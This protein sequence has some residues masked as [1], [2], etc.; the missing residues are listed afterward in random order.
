MTMRVVQTLYT[1]KGGFLSSFFF[2]FLSLILNAAFLAV[3]RAAVRE[4]AKKK[5][6]NQSIFGNVL[7][8]PE[9][10]WP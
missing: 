3:R 8:I 1:N 6:E 9:S 7:F 5:D 10:I 2:N 4:G